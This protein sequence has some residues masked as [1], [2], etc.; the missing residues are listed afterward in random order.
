[1]RVVLEQDGT[2]VCDDI[3]EDFVSSCKD[4]PV[5]MALSAHQEWEDNLLDHEAA[6]TAVT[7]S[8]FLADIPQDPAFVPAPPRPPVNINT[9][10]SW[11]IL[12]NLADEPIY[13]SSDIPITTQAVPQDPLTNIV[14]NT[15]S[16][17]VRSLSSSPRCPTGATELGGQLY[18]TPHAMPVPALTQVTHVLPAMPTGMQGNSNVNVH[19]TPS[20]SAAPAISYSPSNGSVS[21]T[22]ATQHGGQPDD[23]RSV[24]AASTTHP[25]SGDS[26]DIPMS[27]EEGTSSSFGKYI[28]GL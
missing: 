26:I 12:S 28:P 17:P 13:V 19:V 4:I 6:M 15:S 2:E 27:A 25:A 18:D 20:T 14:V 8:G 22:G 10:A 21:S 9:S 23:A 1:M 5:F 11:A 24:P 3:F 16:A 7:K